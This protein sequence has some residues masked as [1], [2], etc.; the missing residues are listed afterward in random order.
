MLQNR[1]YW[2]RRLNEWLRPRNRLGVGDVVRFYGQRKASR[3]TQPKAPG[4][5]MPP[6]PPQ[7]PF[8]IEIHSRT[9]NDQYHWMSHLEDRVAMRHMD[10]YMEQEEKYSEAVMSDTLKLQRKLQSE[11][12]GRMV[13][14]LCTPPLRWGPWLYYEHVVEGKPYPVLCRRLA[15]ANDEFG[16]NNRAASGFDFTTGRKIEQKLLDLNEVAEQFGG[17]VYLET[18]EISPDHHFLAYTVYL[19]EKDFFTLFIK[20]LRSNRL[21]HKPT[22]DRVASLAW[23]KDGYSLLYTVTNSSKRPYRVFCRRLESSEPDTLV[24]EDVDDTCYIH[25]R[26]TKDYE[27]ITI[28]C[29]SNTSSQV[30]FLDAANL[31][32]GM[33]KVWDCES[34]VDCILEHH[35]GYLYMFTNAPRV[36]KLSDGHYL[37]RCPVVACDSGDWENVFIDDSDMWI[38]DA[39]FL[40][41]HMVLILR[42][43][44]T[45]A[46]CSLELPL[47]V[48]LIGGMNLHDL[49]PCFL[50]VP[51]H[52]CQ[53][54]PVT[55]YDFC[56]SVVRLVISSPVMPDAVVDYN[57]SS[58]EWV[59]VEQED[60]RGERT[61]VLYGSASSG[62][63]NT[64]GLDSPK[65]VNKFVNR[66]ED[67][68]DSWN[69][70]SEFY[71]CEQR[72]VCSVDHAYVPLTIVYSRKIKK[73]GQNPGI[74]RGHG[75]YGEVL[76]K[77]WRSD[78]KSLLDR[79]WVI[80]SADVRGGGGGGKS[81]HH[82]GRALKKCNS[83]NDYIACA[84]FLVEE[85]Y[86]QSSKLAAWGYSAGGLLVG[87]AIN[88]C[89]DLFSVA[90]LKVPFLDACNTLLDPIIP[91]HRSDY[92][93]F[94]NPENR[95]DFE[96][97][98]RFSPYE[99][100]Q[101]GV[102]YPAVLIISSFKTRFG[103]WEAA[104]WVSKVRE[105][106]NK[107][108]LRPVLLNVIAGI[109]EENRYLQCKEIAMEI[110]FL[111]K[112][113]D[114]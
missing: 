60:V 111:I 56:S 8:P 39:V 53:I 19:K 7:K 87:A 105:Y 104:K 37:L 76:D 100:I 26:N 18:W 94:G 99:N 63:R 64:K 4:P 91:L 92:D 52:V 47:P 40:D 69:D 97:I 66:V 51:R 21:H 59:I 95:E 33:H 42:K 78:L 65:S 86:V 82:D 13:N 41:K 102:T 25:V 48:N 85:K 45:P 96:N 29:S 103:V 73:D 10:V 71:A 101:K 43:G 31:G 1:G 109:V 27:F 6:K 113:M 67:T 81:W 28:N 75:A 61:Q 2:S 46:V 5:P 68:H 98:Q 15:S 114:T 79:G 22:V 17:Y 80:A 112:M 83:I 77:R 16:W 106:T 55:N 11:M 35:Q 44:R 89:P 38:E 30:H 20:D 9:W 62:N 74:L 23:A 3:A 57:L 72:D 90:I 93:E 88:V 84:K 54:S 110:A 49:N 14:Q 108:P 12:A 50:P 58:R 107:D 32:A 34:E 70:L 24:M 36:G